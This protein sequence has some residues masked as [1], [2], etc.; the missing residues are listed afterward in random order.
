MI[1]VPLE[2]V[3]DADDPRLALAFVS[4][5]VNGLPVRALL[6]SGAGRSALVHRPESN[7]TDAARGTSKGAFGMPSSTQ[8]TNASV[9]FA[10]KDLGKMELAVVPAG[11][12]GHGD[13]IGQDVL[14]HFRCE[15]RL[16]QR[17]LRLDGDMPGEAIPIHLD[18]S[19]HIYLETTWSHTDTLAS[20]VFDTGSSVTVVDL[21]FFSSHPELFTSSGMS[22]GT[23]ASGEVA[24]TPM[25]VMRRP[26]ILG[27][28]LSD[29]LVAVVDLSGANRTV[30]RRM[31]LIL[32]WPIISQA[33]WVIDHA[34]RVA[35]CS[36][37]SS[38]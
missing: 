11:H 20:A 31:D 12:P 4:V 10:G 24:E 32:G 34:S 2:T 16:A 26:V 8:R 29:S 19:R 28:E 5:E 27:S 1:D 6:D 13:L 21:A 17:R 30:E 15:Y 37:T 36:P 23:D 35:T 14:S 22:E 7:V 33:A 25:A 18:A 3:A 9:R 38:P